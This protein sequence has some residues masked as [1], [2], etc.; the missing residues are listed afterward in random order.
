MPTNVMYSH[1]VHVMYSHNQ[2]LGHMH[3]I[4]NHLPCFGFG[5]L[6]EFVRH[7]CKFTHKVE[8]HTKMPDPV[9]SDGWTDGQQKVKMPDPVRS[10]PIRWMDGWTDRQCKFTQSGD[11]RSGPIRWMDGWME[12]VSK[13]LQ[14]HTQIS[15]VEIH[16]KM[17]DPV[18]SER[19]TDGQKK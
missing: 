17:P 3:P 16:T 12:Q 19:W 13:G 2:T 14:I 7:R 9:R 18:R 10:G 5:S 6:A 1:N 8:I 4:A 11:A 15:T